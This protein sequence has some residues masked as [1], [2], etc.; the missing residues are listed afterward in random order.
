MAGL[1]CGTPSKTIWP[2][3]RDKA[4]AFACCKDAV[5]EDGMRALASQSDYNNTPSTTVWNMVEKMKEKEYGREISIGEILDKLE[6]PAVKTHRDKEIVKSF[7]VGEIAGLLADPSAGVADI[8]VGEQTLGEILAELQ[9]DEELSGKQA[10][11][12]ITVGD[13]V[14]F[15]RNNQAIQEQREKTFTLKAKV[16]DLFEMI[17]EENVKNFVQQKTA[18]ASFKPEYVRSKGNI[19]RNWLFLGLF[20]L[21]FAALSTIVLELIDKDKR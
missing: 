10:T 4:A 20:I 9:K 6:D 16:G 8:K 18:E 15:L 5:T 17:G 12:A 14:D 1:N 21:V 11:A 7:T 13:A 2:I 19:L 3:L